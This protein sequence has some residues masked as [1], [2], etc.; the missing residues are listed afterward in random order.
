MAVAYKIESA[1]SKAG[2]TDCG[3]LLGSAI[4]YACRVRR[5]AMCVTAMRADMRKI[6]LTSNRMDLL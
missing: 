1:L 4:S 5:I 3:L 2:I 6:G